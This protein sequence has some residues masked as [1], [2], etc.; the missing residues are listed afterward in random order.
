MDGTGSAANRRPLARLGF[1]WIFVFFFLPFS[2]APAW[3]AEVTIAW[4]PTGDGETRGYRV[5]VGYASREYGWSEDAGP[6][7]RYTLRALEDGRTYYVAVTAYD[8]LGGQSGYSQELVISV[9]GPDHDGDGLS[10]AEELDV[11]GTD[12]GLADTDGDGALDGYEVARGTNPLDRRSTPPVVEWTDYRFSVDLRSEDNDA[13]GVMFRYMDDDHYYRFS[14]DRERSA[15]RLVKKVGGAYGL[16]AERAVAYETGR[17]YRVDVLALGPRLEVHI[18]GRRVLSVMDA[19]LP[20]GTV[21]FYCWANEG[22]VFDNVS[23]QSLASGFSLLEEDFT[24]RLMTDWLVVDEGDIAG[25]SNWSAQSRSLVQGSN[26]R[27]TPEDAPA[28][29]MP[30]SHAVYT[31]V[32]L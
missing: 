1:G 9:P 15:M 12:P 11:L 30:G 4:D 3:A 21:G 8:G 13:M 20:R 16:L 2:A 7:D 25:P 22:S 31:G 14:W 5:H 28:F 17:T 18:D 6:A 23:V 32:G 24:A 19:D 26:I 27:G 29:A 10:D